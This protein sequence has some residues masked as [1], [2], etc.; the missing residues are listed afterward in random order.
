CGVNHEIVDLAGQSA[1]ILPGSNPVIAKG[2]LYNTSSNIGRVNEDHF[3]VIPE[4]QFRL[5]ANLTER[6]S[7]FAGYDFLYIS[8]VVRPVQ[9]IDPVINSALLPTSAQFGAGG[10]AKPEFKFEQTS[11]W[12]HG[13]TVGMTMRY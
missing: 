10:I 3:A 1:L 7:V 8:N 5:G 2:G 4:A 11:F 9:Q 6:L 13:A 12:M